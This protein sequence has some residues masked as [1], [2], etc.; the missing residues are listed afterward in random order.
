M[1]LGTNG[2]GRFT[3]VG[4]CTIRIRPTTVSVSV[5]GLDVASAPTEVKRLLVVVT[6]GNTLD[7]S[8]ILAENLPC[9]CRYFG[10]S[11]RKAIRGLLRD[12]RVLRRELPAFLTR[13]IMQPLLFVFVLAHM[14]PRIGQEVGGTSAGRYATVVVPGLVAVIPSGPVEL[15]V[16]SRPLLLAVVVLSAPPSGALGLALGRY[17]TPRQIGLVFSVVVLP[18]TFVGAV[19]GPWSALDARPWLQWLALLH[20]L[21]YVSE[22][23]R[24]TLTPSIPTMPVGVVLVALVLSTAVLTAVG[25]RG[26]LARTVG[27]GRPA[28]VAPSARRSRRSSQ[29]ISAEVSSPHSRTA[30]RRS[31]ATAPA[32]S[33]VPRAAPVP[34]AVRIQF[35]C[36]S[37]PRGRG[38]AGARSQLEVDRTRGV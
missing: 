13:T 38:D 15:G 17:V 8:V 34:L 36:M 16:T 10:W 28:A 11:R 5:F 12:L 27:C 3:T 29:R 32:A 14:F 24:A 30:P 6:Q 19:Y 26:F 9:Y 18:L 7:R 33:A 31:Q 35:V 1:V 23:L 20:P 25:L 2:A 21:V 22:G 4:I 37:G